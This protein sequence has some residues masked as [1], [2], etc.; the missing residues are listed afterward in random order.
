MRTAIFL[1][2]SFNPLR[3]GSVRIAHDPREMYRDLSLLQHPVVVEAHGDG[4]AVGGDNLDALH[5]HEGVLRLGPLV[6][7]GAQALEAHEIAREKILELRPTS[8]VAG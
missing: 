7:A 2:S 3:I 4:R 6:D 5:D 1:P 8:H